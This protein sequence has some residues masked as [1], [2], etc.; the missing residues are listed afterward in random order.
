MK[1]K[2]SDVFSTFFTVTHTVPRGVDGPGE[3]VYLGLIKMAAAVP[4]LQW[5]LQ[6]LG[7]WVHNRKTPGPP[8]RGLRIKLPTISCKT[9]QFRNLKHRLRSVQP[10]EAVANDDILIA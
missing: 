6:G 4:Q 9:N 2:S 10:A 1:K 7:A 3:M 5:E 8:G